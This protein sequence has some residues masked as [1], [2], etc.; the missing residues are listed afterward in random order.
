[1]NVNIVNVHQRSMNGFVQFSD[2]S[3]VQAALDASPHFIEGREIIVDKPKGRKL[4]HSAGKENLVP[5]TKN[6]NFKSSKMT[7]STKRF[8]PY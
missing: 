3:M 2:K 5:S 6:N 8:S 4:R 1:M 7:T